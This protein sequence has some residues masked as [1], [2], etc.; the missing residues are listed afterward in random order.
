MFQG[1]EPAP[2]FLARTG[3]GAGAL[4]NVGDAET[5]DLVALI[6][7][8]VHRAQNSVYEARKR[9]DDKMSSELLVLAEKREALLAKHQRRIADLFDGLD[10]QAR[11]RTKREREERRD[12]GR[13]RPVVGLDQADPRDPERSE[14]IR[15]PGRGFP[16]L[17]DA[18]R[19]GRNLER[20]RVLLGALPPDR[21]RG[22]RP[23]AARA[24]ARGGKGGRD[25]AG[26]PAGEGRSALAPLGVRLQGRAQRPEAPPH[27]PRVRPRIPRRPRLRARV[28][29]GSRRGGE[30]AADHRA[31]APTSRG[32]IASGSWRPS[33]PRDADFETGPLHLRFRCEQFEGIDDAVDV[34]KRRKDTAETAINKGIFALRHPPRFVILLSMAHA[35]LIDREKWSES[36]LLS[37]DFGEIFTR[38]DFATI[39]AVA[40]LL[41]ATSLAP[42]SGTP[43][44][45]RIDEESHRHAYGVSQD[46]KFSLREAIELLGN[47]AATLIVEKRREQQKGVFSGENALDAGILSTECLRYMYR[48]LFLLYIEARPQLGFAPMNAEA[49]RSGYSL[50]SLRDLALVPLETE[51]DKNGHFISDT[52]DTL[53]RVVFEGTPASGMPEQA[54]QEVFTFAPVR[55]RLFDPDAIGT[56]LRGLR[57]R[58]SVMQRIVELLSLSRE[59]RGRNRGRISYVNLG[60][61][62]LGAVYEF[63]ALVLRLLRRREPDRAEAEG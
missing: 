8:A 10:D 33:A 37:F 6:E 31:C 14:P 63:A 61:S 3:V 60:I 23:G 50:E 19:T 43:L 24:L 40:A 1:V 48:L 56:Y 4:P 29:A 58:N 26:S 49:Y 46:L 18:D 32:T 54:K 41:H 45:D 39:G 22:R 2:A 55:A 47:E 57:F 27:L 51:E 25:A 52:I 13:I 28:P 62:Q 42:D 5:D 59:S 53:F 38:G 20:Q 36:R 9:F 44:V 11:A 35:V 17:N 16:G 21:L 7:E 15:P 34:E 30:A 12:Q